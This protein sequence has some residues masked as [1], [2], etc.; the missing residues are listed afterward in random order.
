MGLLLRFIMYCTLA[1][2]IDHLVVI[3]GVE[4]LWMGRGFEESVYVQGPDHTDMR[5]SPCD[6]AW[7]SWR[8]WQMHELELW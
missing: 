8:T 2:L 7:P 1:C 5:I 4:Y 3:K 6:V